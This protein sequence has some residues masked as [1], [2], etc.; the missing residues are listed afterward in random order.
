MNTTVINS[1]LC[2]LSVLL[3]AVFGLVGEVLPDLV[4]ARQSTGCGGTLA[5]LPYP[6]TLALHVFGSGGGAFWLSLTPFMMVFVG[7]AACVRGEAHTRMFWSGFI[8]TWLLALIYF[9]LYAWSM[10]LP[11]KL[12]CA[13]LDDRPMQWIVPAIDLVLLAVIVIAFRR[14][15]TMK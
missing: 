15:L 1:I 6:T 12:L 11:F 2:G 9:G 8:A 5:A 10:L 3:L 7:L 13:E 14:S 4:Q